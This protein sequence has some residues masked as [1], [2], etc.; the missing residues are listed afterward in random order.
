MIEYRLKLFLM[1]FALIY[2]LKLS[3]TRLHKKE[4]PVT[5]QRAISNRF[6]EVMTWFVG[7]TGLFLSFLF[8][9]INA[10]VF[11]KR[12]LAWL[13][14]NGISLDG[15]N[16]FRRDRSCLDHIY[17]LYA[18]I[19]NGKLYTSDTYACFIDCRK[20]FDTV[21]RN[22]DVRSWNWIYMNIYYKQYNLCIW[23]FHVLYAYM[24]ILPISSQ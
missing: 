6:L 4:C 18:V 21:N 2:Y 22:C 11:N 23:M 7:V 15:Q 9:I 3:S 14:G 8:R 10:N 5:G 17:T 1:I 16:G 12:L 19:Y 20:A 13:E 24:S